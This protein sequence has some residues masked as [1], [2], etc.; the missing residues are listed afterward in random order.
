MH[1]T[2]HLCQSINQSI[3]QST[4]LASVSPVEAMQVLNEPV[5]YLSYRHYQ[6]LLFWEQNP[7]STSH[8]LQLYS[9]FV[10]D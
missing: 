3:N 7:S 4:H 5:A 8:R 6:Q 9:K 10:G 2:T 1:E